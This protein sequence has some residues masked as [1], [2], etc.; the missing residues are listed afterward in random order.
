MTYGEPGDNVSSPI[1][2]VSHYSPIFAFCNGNQRFVL[3]RH[4][5]LSAHCLKSGIS[6]D[7]YRAAVMS[8]KLEMSAVEQ[9]LFSISFP[10]PLSVIETFLITLQPCRPAIPTAHLSP[11]CQLSWPPPFP[12]TL[13]DVFS[14]NRCTLSAGE[15]CDRAFHS[16]FT[17]SSV[18]NSQVQNSN[19]L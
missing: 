19:F 3:K 1:V 17:V 15:Q 18:I 7:L 8:P 13:F 6:K 2:F 5:Q 10:F 9:R 16:S 12:S 11:G 4:W 14:R